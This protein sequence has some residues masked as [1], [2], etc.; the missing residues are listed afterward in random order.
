MLLLLA[1]AFG[2]YVFFEKQID[3]ANDQRHLSWLLADHLRQSSDDLTKLARAYAVTG[4]PFFKEAYQDVLAIRDGR[5]PMP[6]GYFGPYWDLTPEDSKAPDDAKRHGVALLDQMRAAHFTDDELGWIAAA[7][8]TSDDLAALELKAMSLAESKGPDAEADRARAISLLFD[9]S[10]YRTKAQ[11]MRPIDEVYRSMDR[12]TTDRVLAEERNAVVFRW[13][14]V[15]FLLVSVFMIWRAY[16]SLRGSME[17][18]LLESRKL[19]ALGTLAGGVAHD[20]NNIIATVLGNAD[21]ALGDVNGNS[22]ARES[23]EEIRKAGRRG[24]DLVRQ[25]LAF[26]RRQSTDLRP[27]ALAPIIEESARLL[28]AMLP[29][30]VALDVHCDADVPTV[31]ADANQIQQVLINLATNSM[32]A[33]QGRPGGIRIRVDIATFD[34]ALEDAHPQL[35]AFHDQHAGP[36]VRIAVSD[37]GVGMDAATL[38]RVFEPFFTTKPLGEGTGLGLSV[39]H[40]ILQTHGG[41]ILVQSAPGTGTTFTLYLPA[42]KSQ[43]VAPAPAASASSAAPSRGDGKR[44]LYLDDDEALV[45][46]TKRMLERRGYSVGG[47]SSPPEALAAL[48]ADPTSFDLVLSDYNMPGLSGLDVAR[49]VLAMRP[50]LPV[51]IISGFVDE[52]LQAQAAAAGVMAVMFKATEVE[53]LCEAVAR[54]ANAIA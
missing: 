1:L 31:S 52:T 40:G 3:R 54:L 17:S 30:R 9:A 47:Y 5:M 16:V 6:E 36:V 22:R 12:R 32:Q 39:V 24:R 23:L 2:V 43:A 21:L 34:P 35:R 25:I 37:D 11:I 50:D 18:R 13:V 49:E 28:R 44:I 33:L 46:L 27:I 26:S 38:E 7:K 42:A 19:A 29:A 48:R 51:A 14:F 20:F 15:A 4:R 10:Y 53:E 45:F 41:V 8:K